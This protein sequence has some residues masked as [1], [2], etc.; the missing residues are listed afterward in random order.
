[1]KRY[2]SAAIYLLGDAENER[3]VDGSVQSTHEVR[4]KAAVVLGASGLL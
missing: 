1:M 4:L 3:L 2:K